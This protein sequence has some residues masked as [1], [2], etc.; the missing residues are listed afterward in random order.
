MKRPGQRDFLP[1]TGEVPG[2]RLVAAHVL[3]LPMA[4]GCGVATV[5]ALAV[6]DGTMPLRLLAVLGAAMGAVSF[7]IQL[8]VR[9]TADPGLRL[10]CAIRIAPEV[11][12]QDLVVPPLPDPGPDDG[13]TGIP[14]PPA[15]DGPTG[16][17]R[18]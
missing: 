4:F 10:T 8:L 1:A 9:Y 12:G 15:T 13:S 14:G 7:F 16:G 2:W 6:T 18:S 3:P 5:K 17:D 11:L